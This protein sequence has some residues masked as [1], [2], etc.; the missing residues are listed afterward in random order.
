M[1]IKLVNI[2]QNFNYMTFQ[3]GEGEE[4]RVWFSYETPVA[5]ENKG[6]LK[7]AQNV[8]S[9]TTGKHLNKIDGGDKE[10]R[11]TREEFEKE[12]AKFLAKIK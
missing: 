8:W 3:K 7:V 5:F 2:S 11:L 12:L 10:T 1:T 4:N 9:K 6:V